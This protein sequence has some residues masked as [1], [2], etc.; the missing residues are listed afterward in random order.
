MSG[1]AQAR[2]IIGFGLLYLVLAAVLIASPSM[3]GLMEVEVN[4]ADDVLH[5]SLGLVSCAVGLAA[6]RAQTRLG[7]DGPL[8][9]AG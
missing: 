8:D 3:F 7:H 4:T 6:Y 2:G 5:V 9:R 1:A